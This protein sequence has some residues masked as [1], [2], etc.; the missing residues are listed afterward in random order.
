M[1]RDF[2]CTKFATG[3]DFQTSEVYINFEYQGRN[4]VMRASA[5]GYAVAWL[6]HHPYGYRMRCTEQQ[7]KSRALR[8]G[9]ISV[10]SILRDWIKG[11]ITAI[12]VGMFTFEG[13][14][15]SHIMLPSGMSVIEEVQAKGM[16]PQPVLKA[17]ESR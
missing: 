1:L 6:K 17:I 9:S 12:E 2:G 7:H 4:I 14:F 11:Q 10:Y 8:Q 15:L 5:K 16:L 13:A 3:E